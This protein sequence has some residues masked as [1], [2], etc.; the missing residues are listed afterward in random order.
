MKDNP[1]KTFAGFWRRVGAFALDYVII[2]VYL[3]AITLFSLLMNS[4]FSVNQWLFGDRIRAQ[5]T[6][7]LFITLPVSL[8]FAFSESSIRQA[9]WGKQR[10]G[11]K[12]TDRSGN[13]I[14]L[15]RSVARTVLKFI[16]WE[17]AHTMI[18]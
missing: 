12:V 2:L 13:R 14:G 4:L 1:M 15:W 6:G 18:S 7:F 17:L 10:L 16:P 5:V 11:L 3:V 9:T 8:Y